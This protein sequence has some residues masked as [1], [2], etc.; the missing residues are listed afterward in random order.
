MLEISNL[1]VSFLNQG[2]KNLPVLRDITLKMQKEESL[3]LIGES[4]CGKTILALSIVKLLPPEAKI[5][6]GKISF[7]GQNLIN[8]K[9]KQLLQIRGKQ[10]GFIFQDP[11][12]AL[13][14]VFK[15]GEQIGE[16][17]CY[18]FKLSKLQAK[19]KVLNFFE[20]IGFNEPKRIY[21]SYPH[22]LSGGMRQRVVI[23]LAICCNPKLI[24][25]DEPTT[26]LDVTIQAQILDLLS[27]IKN[28][29]KSAI[30]FISHDL[31]LVSNVC[32]SLCVMYLG[33]II[34]QG[35]LEVI[36]DNP[37]HPY[38]QGLLEALPLLEKDKELRPIPGTIHPLSKIP[39]GCAFHPR[40]KHKL[41][42]CGKKNPPDIK[43]NDLQRVKCWLY[44]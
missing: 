31:S 22:E 14:P 43:V 1:N 25:A 40:C 7:L 33:Q 44:R 41:A 21:N 4:G 37:L 38:T 20:K 10:I 39:K 5:C 32:Q 16:T 24:I 2:G 15:V 34:E 18:H 19:N 23:A 29:Q 13:N 17:L 6:Q 9:E 12:T 11:M 3:A 36:L 8:Y 28:K 42:I 27:K 35:N 26:A 30:L